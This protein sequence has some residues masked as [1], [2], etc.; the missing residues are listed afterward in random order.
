MTEPPAGWKGI[1]V[2]VA[3]GNVGGAARWRAELEAHLTLSQSSVRQIGRGQYLTPKWLFQRERLAAQASLV[4][5]S[6]NMSFVMRG[7]RRR[8]LLRNAMHFLG[9][10]ESYLLARMPRSFRNQI[11]LVRAAAIRAHEIVVPSTDMA[12]RVAAHLPRA[13]DRIFIR[14]HPVTPVGPRRSSADSFILVPVIPGPYKNLFPQIR[15]LLG[16]IQRAQLPMKLMLTALSSQLPS[17]IAHDPRVS[18]IG[19]VPHSRLAEIW[20][21]A[22]AAFYPSTVE[23]FGYPLAEARAYGIPIIAPNRPLAMEIAGPA[24]AAYDPKCPES[25][26]AAVGKIDSPLE[27]DPTCFE[28]DSYFRWL[29][30]TEELCRVP[31]HGGIQASAT[32]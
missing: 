10:D 15:L 21:S 27:A 30:E 16:A 3:G 24:L 26:I 11:C 9:R 28:R 1:V 31:I 4:V 29:F 18:T 17:D 12:Q 5:A 2:D 20:R 6:N 25:L 19:V 32:Q 14:P 7:K 23:S 22:S 13:S 8:L